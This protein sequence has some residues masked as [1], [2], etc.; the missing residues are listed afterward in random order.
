MKLRGGRIEGQESCC[1]Y[2]RVKVGQ[3]SKGKRETPFDVSSDQI[4]D[5]N[6]IH[7]LQRLDQVTVADIS[8]HLLQNAIISPAAIFVHLLAGELQNAVDLLVQLPIAE[9]EIAALINDEISPRSSGTDLTNADAS[10]PS[11]LLATVWELVLK[12][13]NFCVQWT[14]ISTLLSNYPIG[15][16]LLRDHTC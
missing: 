10:G 8:S 15:D 14:A 4:N 13:P 3:K 11:S 2:E 6:F 9:H 1:L 12:H 7:F 16:L 5:A